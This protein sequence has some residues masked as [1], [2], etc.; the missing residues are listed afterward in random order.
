M[1]SYPPLQQGLV[2]FI[3]IDKFLTVDDPN[4]K[5]L[6]D[7][8]QG[9]YKACCVTPVLCVKSLSA[10]TIAKKVTLLTTI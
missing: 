3:V 2:I 8:K 5:E 7:M 4:D 1:S 10:C 6:F 9:W